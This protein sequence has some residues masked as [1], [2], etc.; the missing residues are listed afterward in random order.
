MPMDSA[1]EINALLGRG[2]EFAGKLTFEGTVRVD[3]KFE[4]EV[5]SHDVLVV[6]DGAEVRAEID[7]GT[8]IVKG[9]LVVGNIRAREAVEIHAPGRLLGNITSPSLYIGKGVVFDGH[10]QMGDTTGA[11]PQFVPAQAAPEPPTANVQPMR[12]AP[13]APPSPVPFPAAV[14]PFRSRS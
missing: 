2:T 11:P 14:P 3:G 8:L 13:A 5:F 10:C 9:G 1:M 12:F 6:G 7:V 4:G